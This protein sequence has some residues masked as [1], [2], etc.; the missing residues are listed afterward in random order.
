MKF[1]WS[2]HRVSD[3]R[4]VLSSEDL[5]RRRGEVDLDL[6]ESYGRWLLLLLAAQ[7]VAANSLM[8]LYAWHGHDWVVP[9]GVMKAW[10]ASTVV[11]LIGVVYVVVSHLFPKHG[12]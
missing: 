2:R 9:E 12:G 3:Q 11:E 4:P 1:P 6:K 8:F 5:D 7:L 10:L